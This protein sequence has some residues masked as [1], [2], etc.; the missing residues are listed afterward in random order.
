MLCN[1]GSGVG[2]GR[3]GEE[4][5]V[6]GYYFHLNNFSFLGNL[7][8]KLQLSH[9]SLPRAASA[10]PTC[11]PVSALAY[12]YLEENGESYSSLYHSK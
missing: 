1:D 7:E 4:K 6:E 11:T 3:A 5:L 12:A 2:W 8:K 9:V 10:N